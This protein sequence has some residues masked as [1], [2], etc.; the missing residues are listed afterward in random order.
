VKSPERKSIA[1]IYGNECAVLIKNQG[2]RDMISDPR[3]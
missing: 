2:I 3:W 1:G